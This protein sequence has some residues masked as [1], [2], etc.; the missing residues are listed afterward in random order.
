M[1]R[2]TINVIFLSTLHRGFDFT[3]F[4]VS[5][6]NILKADDK[7]VNKE[8]L[9]LLNQNFK[10]LA[11]I[12]ETYAVWLQRNSSHFDL[13]CFFKELKLPAVEMVNSILCSQQF[14]CMLLIN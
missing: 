6:V 1:N 2:C 14:A 10:I 9:Q 7:Q 11:D 13:T 3:L 4:A 5:V 12:E 8:I